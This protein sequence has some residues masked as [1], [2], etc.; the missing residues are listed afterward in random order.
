MRSLVRTRSR[1]C[2]VGKRGH[3]VRECLLDMPHSNQGY[4]SPGGAIRLGRYKLLEYYEN[5]R[6]QLFDL[7]NDIGEQNDL[8]ELQPAIAQRLKKMLHDWRDEVDA[9]M[10]Y[11]K[12]ATSVPAPGARV[13]KPAKFSDSDNTRKPGE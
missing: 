11:P 1:D 5:G 3:A 2:P 4:Q 8:A 7:E 9:K 10:P 12:M 13:A 6:V